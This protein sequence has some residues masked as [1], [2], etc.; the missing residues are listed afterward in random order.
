MQHTVAVH[1]FRLLTDYLSQQGHNVDDFLAAAN[2]DVCLLDDANERIRYQ[3]FARLCER[4]KDQFNEPFLGIK[5]GQNAKPPHLGSLGF[6]LMASSSGLEMMQQTARY[7]SLS[8]DAAHTVFEKKGNRFIRY[9]RSNLPG[10]EALGQ[11]QDELSHAVWVSLRRWLWNRQDLKLHWVSFRHEAP[12]DLT[13]YENF[14]RCELRF[15]C[16]ENALCFNAGSENKTAPLAN[17]HMFNAMNDMC[18]S[19]VQKLGNR[20]EPSWL[21]QARQL[22]ASSFKQG[23]PDI[24]DIAAQ[25]DVDVD[26]FK[27]QLSEREM[28]FRAITDELRHSLAVGYI[29]DSKLS[30]VDIAFLLG[31]SEQS[32]FQRAFKRWT[33]L[34]P[35][36]YRAGL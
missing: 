1:F 19:L 25:L 8:I 7:T 17:A 26:Q 16:V 28:S 36:K 23:M 2:F 27:Q 14:F 12:N 33:G 10:G 22:I 29:R 6:S 18:E 4:A 20:H 30:L 35:G 15:G 9:R 3:D 32:A 5:L 31:F 11:L 21:A 24:E 34:P 13:E